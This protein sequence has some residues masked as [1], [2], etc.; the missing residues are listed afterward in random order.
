MT[1]RIIIS[2]TDS[3]GD[4]V[5]TLPMAGILKEA[6][7]DMVIYFLGEA[8]VQ[9]VVESSKHIDRFLDWNA[10]K[11]MA[12]HEQIEL[13][14][15]LNADAIIHTFPNPEIAKIAKKAKIPV[16]IGS[17]HRL[18]H[19]FSC[20]HPVF[21]SRRRSGLHESQL[22]LKLLKPLG[23]KTFIPKESISSYYGLNVPVELPSGHESLL[24]P[25][26]L[27]VI[28]HPTSRGSA[29]EWG[30][31]NFSGL[32]ELL[33]SSEYHILIS[34]T[35]EDRRLLDDFLKRH[36]EKVTDI[37]GMMTL[38]EFT[39]FIAASDGL[40]AASTGPLHI[41]AALGKAVVGIYAP[42]RP[43]HPGRW[44]PLGPNA[45]VLVKNEPCNACKNDSECQ[46]IRSIPPQDVKHVLEA[47]LKKKKMQ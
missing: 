7:P 39:R 29:R 41:A 5:L 12:L 15:S 11:K 3:I 4:V 14:R 38:N 31:D 10:V 2:R 17:G 8:I 26:R 47:A 46:C 9:P 44:G 27:N 33:P 37:A 23:L 16:R 21:F 13:F 6:H 40:V 36:K 18:Y 30:L 1:K 25:K 42:M 35:K 45:H 24:D 28:L 22:N 43:I 32:I 34:G 19:L 20:N